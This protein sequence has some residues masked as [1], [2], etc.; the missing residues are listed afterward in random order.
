MEALHFS[1]GGVVPGNKN[2]Q[3]NTVN[4]KNKILKKKKQYHQASVKTQ[5][6]T[7]VSL[8]MITSMSHGYS[9]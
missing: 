4:N 7:K 3:D 6:V 1:E 5:W 8:I 2:Y 9:M